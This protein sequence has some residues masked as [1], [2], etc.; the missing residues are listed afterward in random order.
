LGVKTNGA[1]ADRLRGCDQST[2]IFGATSLASGSAAAVW[3]RAFSQLVVREQFVD[4]VVGVIGQACDEVDQIGLGIGADEPAVLYQGEE[5]G[6]TGAGIGV[7]LP[8]EKMKI[9]LL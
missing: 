9:H 3:P 6:Q 1:G 4:A 7:A 2:A 5:I 8:F